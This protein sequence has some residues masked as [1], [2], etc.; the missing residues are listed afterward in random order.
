MAILQRFIGGLR[1]LFRSKRVE[2]ELDEELRGYLESSVDA[3][4]GGGMTR[5]DAR[6]AGHMELGSI[7]SVKDR[8][9]DVGWETTVEHAWRDVRYAVRTLRKSPAFA[10]VVVLTLTLGIG[11]NTAIFSAVNAIM[12]R[13]LPAERPDEL[14]AL[15]ALYPDGAE[16]F[17][18]AAYRRIASDGAPL[19]DALAASTAQR[20]AIRS[21]D[22]CRRGAPHGSIRS[23][24]SGP[25]RRRWLEGANRGCDRAR[26][27][28]V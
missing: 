13:A 2:Q 21:Q 14:I 4:V 28:F 7:E 6:R 22:I 3:K 9:R 25:S 10:L 5:D 19:A 12:L 15:K 20:D 1:G 17:S 27:S 24:R 26:S 8:T 18:Y 16:P 23:P 11:A